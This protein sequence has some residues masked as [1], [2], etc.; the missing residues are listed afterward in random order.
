MIK[1]LRKITVVLSIVVA[2]MFNTVV[3]LSPKREMRSTWL[4]TVWGIDWPQLKVQQL[5]LKPNKRLN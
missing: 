2:M 1:N 5:Q 4:T 3:A